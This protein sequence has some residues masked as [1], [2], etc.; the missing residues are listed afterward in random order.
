MEVAVTALVMILATV[1]YLWRV[2][3]ASEK[4]LTQDLIKVKIVAEAASQASMVLAERLKERDDQIDGMVD[5]IS[6]NVGTD[7]IVDM[8]NGRVSQD[9]QGSN[10]PEGMP[11]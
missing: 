2:S 10:D 4:E 7:G 9:G 6:K 11:N 5:Y 8:L 3:A 1:I